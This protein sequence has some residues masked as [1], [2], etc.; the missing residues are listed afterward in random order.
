MTTEKVDT[1]ME[2]NSTDKKYSN[3][4][5]IFARCVLN[6]NLEKVKET[7]QTY[8]CIIEITKSEKQKRRKKKKRRKKQHIYNWNLCGGVKKN[9]FAEIIDKSNPDLVEENINL[10]T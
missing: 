1:L 3:W 7:M 6:S 8:R 10:L 2:E 9:I 4:Y 5:T